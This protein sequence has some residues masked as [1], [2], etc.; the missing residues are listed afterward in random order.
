VPEKQVPE[1]AQFWAKNSPFRVKNASK[2][3]RKTAFLC[4]F[5]WLGASSN[6]FY[7]QSFTKQYAPNLVHNWGGRGHWKRFIRL[8]R[9]GDSFVD[10]GAGEGL[11]P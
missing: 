7:F 5:G 4:S 8:P 9:M 3:A 10:A 1:N 11:L 6:K 2:R